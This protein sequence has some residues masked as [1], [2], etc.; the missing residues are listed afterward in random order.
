MDAL[1]WSHAEAEQRNSL[2]SPIISFVHPPGLKPM[3]MTLV[4]W[5][6]FRKLTLKRRRYHSMNVDIRAI[7]RYFSSGM[8]PKLFGIHTNQI[9]F[10]L[11]GLPSQKPPHK[12]NR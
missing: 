7:R 8:M 1:I 9:H 2:I 12:E 10:Q 4:L 3:A 5:M 6:V 11:S